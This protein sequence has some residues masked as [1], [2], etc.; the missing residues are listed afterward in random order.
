MRAHFYTIIF[1]LP[2]CLAVADTK[3]ESNER[4]QAKDLKVLPIAPQTE[5]GHEGKTQTAFAAPPIRN[6]SAEMLRKATQKKKPLS[7]KKTKA[8]PSKATKKAKGPSKKA[9]KKAKPKKT[10]KK[11]KR[12]KLT[13]AKSKRP[14]KQKVK[15]K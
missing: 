15:K 10:T 13:K 4:I 7:P 2:L 8:T 6:F 3:D 14:S 12:K 5:D 1:L 9:T 11:A